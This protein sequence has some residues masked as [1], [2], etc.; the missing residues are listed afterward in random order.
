MEEVES[1][2]LLGIWNFLEKK[3]IIEPE[4]HDGISL[5]FVRWGKCPILSSRSGC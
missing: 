2:V 4:N 1:G 3:A 5:F